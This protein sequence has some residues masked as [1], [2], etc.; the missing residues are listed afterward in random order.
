MYA[1]EA[2]Q[3]VLGALLLESSAYDLIGGKLTAESFADP[4]HRAVYESAASLAVAGKSTDLVSVWELLGQRG[5]QEQAGGLEYLNALSQCVVTARNAGRHA[6]IV[7][8]RALKRALVAAA[9]QAL[10]IAGEAGPVSEKLDEIAALFGGLERGTLSKA[11]RLLGDVM[12]ERTAAYEE[13]AS[14]DRIAGWSTG[15]PQLDRRL[16]GG[17]KPGKL[18]IL[19]ARPSVG[20]SSFSMSMLSSVGR[21]GYPCLFL[22]QEMEN[23]EL[24]DRSISSIGHV[25][26]EHIQAGKF[27]GDDWS[28]I[29]KA[30]EGARGMPLY[31]D[32]QPALTL[33]DVRAKARSIKG[34][35]VLVL[36]YLQL[37]SSGLKGENRNAQIEEISRGLKALAKQLGICIVALSQLN[38]EVEKRP[39]R[40]PILSDL[41]DSGAIEQDADAVLFLWPVKESDDSPIRIVGLDVAKIRGGRKGAFCLNFDGALQQWLESTESVDSFAPAKRAGNFE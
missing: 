26:Q 5:K 2:E 6:E 4:R 3:S 7:A 8:D 1:L 27:E 20:K 14:G 33:A 34:L 39:G 19:A 29:I 15:V 31:I 13:M 10:E 11:P 28:R 36:D 16:G 30:V 35:K 17:L 25:D 32:D 18:I 23:D 41:R 12:L 21:V 40:R 9:Q 24:A 22:S 37:C 38:R